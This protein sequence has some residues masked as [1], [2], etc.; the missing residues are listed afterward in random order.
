M[1]AAKTTEHPNVY[2]ALAAAQGEFPEIPKTKSSNAY[3]N[4]IVVDVKNDS[5]QAWLWINQVVGTGTVNLAV[6]KVIATL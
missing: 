1:P 5:P 3:G 4:N 6:S 2:A